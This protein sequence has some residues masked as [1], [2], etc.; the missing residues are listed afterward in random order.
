MVRRIIGGLTTLGVAL[1]LWVAL[2]CS[3]GTETPPAEASETA[4]VLAST[5]TAAEYTP[6]TVVDGGSIG[7][8]VTIN[9]EA[10]KM[11]PIPVAK[12][13]EICGNEIADNSLEVGD[14][15]GVKNAVVWIEEISG[16]KEGK[17]CTK[18]DPAVLDQ[19]GCVFVPR[20]LVVNKGSSVEYRSSSDPI[21]HN[22]KVVSKFGQGFNKLFPA[23]AAG[24]GV[25]LEQA[26]MLSVN[27]DIHPWMTA[28][29]H[30][31]AN[32]YWALTGADGTFK[33]D[34]VPAG[35]YSIKI[36]HEKLKRKTMEVTVEGGKEAKADAALDVKKKRR[37]K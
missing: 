18:D 27:C 4:A 5:G 33:I 29:L 16:G 28:K 31:M 10:P 25:V 15:G 17:G 7:G 37:R 3:G 34:D 32:P 21:A 11:E 30:V 19:K 6:G 36:W 35:K 8:T 1:G 14:G 20:V 2:A 23:G 26:E 9:G 13:Q 22:T 24:E 12:D